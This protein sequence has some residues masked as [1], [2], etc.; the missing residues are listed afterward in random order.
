VTRSY[1]AVPLE[2][3]DLEAAVSAMRDRSLRVSAS[4]R[5]VLETLYATDE[6]LTA[7]QIA[8]GLD[9]RMPS[10]DLTSVYRNLEKLE[11]IGLVRH[12]HIGHG[13]GLYARAGTARREFLLCDLCGSLRALSP[14]ALDP[15]RELIRERFGHDARFDHFPIGGL[16]ERCA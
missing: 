15:V 11:E 13:P 6:P 14:D 2:A 3:P 9:G 4:R 1:S 8:N 5:L 7:E 16:C 12:F 10:S